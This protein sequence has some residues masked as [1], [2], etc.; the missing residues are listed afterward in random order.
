MHGV[1][2]RV[3]SVWQNERKSRDMT[4]CHRQLILRTP[5]ECVERKKMVA[6]RMPHECVENKSGSTTYVTNVLFENKNG[7][8]AYTMH[9]KLRA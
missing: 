1:Y 3:V 6:L 2:A 4:R 5:H 8:T 7:S 9:W